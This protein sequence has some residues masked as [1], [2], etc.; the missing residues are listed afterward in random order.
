MPDQ[1]DNLRQLVRAHRAWRETVLEDSPAPL[2]GRRWGQDWL[3]L[4]DPRG[5]ARPWG[6]REGWGRARLLAIV[7]RWVLGRVGR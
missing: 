4:A 6:R 3:R 7:A 1:A 2:A 5:D